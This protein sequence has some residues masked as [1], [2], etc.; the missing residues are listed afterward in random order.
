MRARGRRS[1]RAEQGQATLEALA[2][3]PLLIALGLGLL[4]LL[5]VGYTG[6]LAGNAAEAGALALA[7]GGDPEAEVRDALPGWSKPRVKVAAGQ[8]EVR[9]RPPSPLR[10]LANR[11]EVGASAALDAPGKPAPRPGGDRL[12]GAAPGGDRGVG[13]APGGALMAQ[14]RPEAP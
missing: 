13:P 2:L 7:S 9:L 1:F 14:P 3:V 11:L 12:V 6:V 5:A 8:V 10:A 4:Q